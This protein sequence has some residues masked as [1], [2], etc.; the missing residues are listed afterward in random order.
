NDMRF[1]HIDQDLHITCAVK[2]N[3]RLNQQKKL[4][5]LLRGLR[6][7]AGFTQSELASRLGTDQT[8][9]SKYE[10][11]ER[12]LDILELREVCQATGTDF[13]MFIRKLDK[14]LGTD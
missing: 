7:E 8:F 13:V 9:V 14:D 5:V 1:S 2:K 3:I 12:R 6:V 11:G 10:S 4:L